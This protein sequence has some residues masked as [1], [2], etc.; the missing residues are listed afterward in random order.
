[1]AARVGEAYRFLGYSLRDERGRPVDRV[2]PGQHLF[3]DLYW[4]AEARPAQ[5]HTVF[6]HLV[7]EAHNPA[8]GGPVWAGHDGEP[9][10]GAVPTPHWP[11]GV[12]LIDRHP[13]TVDP[14]APPGTYQIE[15]GLYDPNTGQ[16]LPVAGDGADPANR[17][18]LVGAVEVRP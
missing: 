3:I 11:P 16:R 12:V 17:R 5:R 8:T 14:G 1:M 15:V 10:L 13:L 18:L 4:K 6:A 7:G 9:L 2:R